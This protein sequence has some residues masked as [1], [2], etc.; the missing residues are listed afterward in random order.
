MRS[1]EART[2]TRRPQRRSENHPCRDTGKDGAY[3]RA[4][5]RRTSDGL[6]LGIGPLAELVD[7]S[8]IR[9]DGF[10]E[11]SFEASD[12]DLGLARTRPTA[13]VTDG[14]PRTLKCHH[15]GRDNEYR[16]ATCR[17]PP[18][19]RTHQPRTVLP[20]RRV[21]RLNLGQLNQARV[22]NSPKGSS[23][24]RRVT[25]PDS[26]HAVIPAWTHRRSAPPNAAPTR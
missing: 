4:G 19:P 5:R 20:R 23:A 8:G 3:Q 16:Q 6:K 7:R 18:L 26:A 12:P 10:Q 11:P 25:A 22:W 1:D 14:L 21:P 24:L 2:K 15:G 9:G 17:Q 13:I